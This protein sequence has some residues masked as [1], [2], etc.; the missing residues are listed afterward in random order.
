M[1]LHAKTELL[2]R[3]SAAAHVEGMRSTIETVFALGLMVDSAKKRAADDPHLSDAGRAASVAKVAIDNVKPLTESTAGARK[4]A[5]YNTDRRAALKPQEPRRDDVVG[6]M[7]RQELRAFARTL[8]PAERLP[9][10]L[11]NPE[12][13]LSAPGA[14]SGLPEDQFSKVRETYI[15]SKF[16]PEIAEIEIL[17]GDLATVKAASDMAMNELRSAAGLSERAFSEMVE[18][19]TRETD[20]V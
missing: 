11:A 20:G 2:K 19:V 10:A 13:V 16:G 9:F 6:E 8:K 7:R 18:K 14:L 1:N 17:D 15:A 5:R 4:A 12:A 3:F